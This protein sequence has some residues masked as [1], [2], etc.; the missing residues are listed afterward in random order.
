MTNII[1]F[2]SRYKIRKTEKIKQ[3]MESNDRTT[4]VKDQQQ[5]EN[6]R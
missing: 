4:N 5:L 3:G 1:V 2:R 6:S